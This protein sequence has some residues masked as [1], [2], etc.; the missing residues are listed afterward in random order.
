MD[1]TQKLKKKYPNIDWQ[2][3]EQESQMLIKYV[4]EHSPCVFTRFGDGELMAFE[5]KRLEWLQQNIENALRNSAI[6]GFPQHYRHANVHTENTPNTLTQ[7]WDQE[8]R[9]L[10]SQ[11]NIDLSQKLI[12]GTWLPIYYPSLL[13]ALVEGKRVLWINETASTI[14]KNLKQ[15][16]FRT[17]YQLNLKQSFG[18]NIAPMVGYGWQMTSEKE[19][20]LK[21]IY[22]F[23]L[24][25]SQI[26]DKK[27]DLI[28][29]GA[30]VMSKN[31]CVELS[32][33][34]NVNCIDIGSLLSALS[35]RAD[36][37]VFEPE[38]LMDCLVW[39]P[40]IK[41]LKIRINVNAIR[42]LKRTIYRTLKA[43]FNRS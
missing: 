29:V 7:Q 6:V 33:N 25:Q 42:P 32:Q 10:C 35:G 43:V 26:Y 27:I 36:R 24:T 4:E 30:G 18:I 3:I 23:I 17:Y 11:K 20:E 21:Q 5:G 31:L 34:L 15:K 13:S 12:V 1:L 16:S 8:L 28:V 38:N 37:K 41:K 14:L 39:Y 40:V 19:S 22:Q 9:S 2:A